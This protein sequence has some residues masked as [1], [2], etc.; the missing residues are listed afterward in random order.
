[1]DW[2]EI[3]YIQYIQIS[4]QGHRN[5]K[6]SLYLNSFATDQN[7]NKVT[8]IKVTPKN[9]SH[10]ILWYY[11]LLHA[12]Y[13][14]YLAAIK[15]LLGFPMFSSNCLKIKKSHLAFQFE[16]CSYHTKKKEVNFFISR[17]AA[18]VGKKISFMVW[19]KCTNKFSSET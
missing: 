2:A 17:L 7:M 16:I 8:F 18:G 19:W 1:M 12:V 13:H 10:P 3:L 15:F 9:Q 11:F 4:S 5:N 6:I 14:N